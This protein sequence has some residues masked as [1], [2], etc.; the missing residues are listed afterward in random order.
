VIFQQYWDEE[1]IGTITEFVKNAME[2]WKENDHSFSENRVFN[3][4][5]MIYEIPTELGMPIGY[6]I[7]ASL[8]GSFNAEID[9]DDEA[10]EENIHKVRYSTRFNFQSNN[11]LSLFYSDKLAFTVRQDRV[12]KHTFGNRI[13]FGAESRDEENRMVL[14]LDVPEQ[15]NPFSLLMH[16]QTI[17]EILPNKFADDSP[18]LR[19]RCPTCHQKYVLSGGENSK[20]QDS[21]FDLS[22]EELGMQV[23]ATYFDCEAKFASSKENLMNRISKFF[24]MENKSPKDFYTAATLGLVQLDNFF[25]YF[26]YAESCGMSLEWLQS[27]YNPINEVRL[28]FRGLMDKSKKNGGGTYRFNA[29]LD[30]IGDIIRQHVI[31]F[32]YEYEN[33]RPNIHTMREVYP[34]QEYSLKLKRKQFELGAFN[35]P[36]YSICADFANKM[37]VENDKYFFMDLNSEQKTLT[38]GAI[39]FG[40]SSNCGANDHKIRIT[41]KSS[42]TE[43]ARNHLKSKWYYYTCMEQ[44][45]SKE[46]NNFPLTDACFYTAEDLFTLR[47]F[48]FDVETINLPLWLK[49]GLYKVETF[50]KYY[51]LPYWEMKMETMMNGFTGYNKIKQDQKVQ[52]DLLFNSAEKTV[53]FKMKRMNQ[54][55]EFKGMKYWTSENNDVSIND[56]LPSSSFSSPMEV[57][58]D[59]NIFNYCTA[60]SKH[61]RTF[62]NV[63]YSYEMHDCWT[64]VSAHCAGDPEYAV[65]MKKDQHQQM[66][67]MVYIGGH[68]VEIEPSSSSRFDITVNEGNSFDLS[69]DDTYYFPS[70]NVVANG[71]E[72]E[73]SYMFKIYK[74]E[75]TFTIDSFLRM[76]LHYDGSHVSVISPPHVKGQ[77]CGMCGDFNRDH[78][79]EML[80]PNECQLKNGNDMAKAWAWD[81]EGSGECPNPDEDCEYSEENYFVKQT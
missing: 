68:K 19:R 78:R 44:K 66:A 61:I 7:Q 74:W 3:F 54:Q 28:S 26:P 32:K 47:H 53:D 80:G 75:S 6:D 38:G 39:S 59:H 14:A 30:L 4:P 29:D 31:N 41:G 35:V 52:F 46:F 2:M 8:L 25:M 43:E 20:K 27:A 42:T 10:H 51:L 16:S 71:D 81:K 12:Y 21:L 72:R 55:S 17:L 62:D 36:D 22:S 67:L 73:K 13:K 40:P 69:K 5:T 50:G 58:N 76:T 15:G 60:S 34:K 11:G 24:S 56:Y 37:S 79:Y 77:Q 45:K 64:L 65:F 49:N 33:D 23:K 70:G 18:E 48:Q 63:T 57:L 9:P 1:S